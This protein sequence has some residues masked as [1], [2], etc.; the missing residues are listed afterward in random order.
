MENAVN[1]K[2]HNKLGVGIYHLD[3]RWCSPYDFNRVA[4]Y[5][6]VNAFRLTTEAGSSSFYMGC[7]RAKETGEQIWYS[8]PTFFPHKETLSEFMARLDKTI[9]GIKK[10][11]LWDTVVGFQW[12]EP[13]LKKG[14]NNEDFLAM[15]KAISEEYGKRIFP[16]FSGY[17]VMGRKG[18]LEDNDGDTVLRYESTKYITDVAFDLYG[19]DF[20]VPLREEDK[21]RYF[22]TYNKEFNTAEE[23]L[24]FYTDNLIGRMQNPDS[25]RLW[26]FACAYLC[27]RWVGGPLADEDFCIQSLEGFK[28]LLLKQKNPGGLFSYGYKSWGDRDHLDW[29]I[30]EDNPN[31]W[32]R[33][34]EAAA[35][36][37]SELRDI[38]IK[39]E[40]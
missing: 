33:Y 1:K 36:V 9:S 17:E 37:C 23:F 39:E 20:R 14:H 34:I 28:N 6:M 40:R 11:E 16:V 10:Q 18:N 38:D 25:V 24:Q 30:D 5:G 32:K 27:R 26:Y 12:D 4:N 31:Q 19:Y 15:T 3:P 29:Q 13:L 2:Y 22:D 21:K 7:R 8:A 35:R